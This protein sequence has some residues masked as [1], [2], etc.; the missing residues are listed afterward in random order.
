MPGTSKQSP[1][2]VALRVRESGAGRV[3]HVG[4]VKVLKFLVGK[5]AAPL[6]LDL[7]PLLPLHPETPTQIP[8]PS[9][10]TLRTCPLFPLAPGSPT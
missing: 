9:P 4:M 8:L 6:L 1:A 10:H 7:P 5:A 3:A 2:A